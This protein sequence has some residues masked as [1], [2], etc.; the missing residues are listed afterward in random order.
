MVPFE[1]YHDRRGSV[2]GLQESDGGIYSGECYHYRQVCL[3]ELHEVG[4]YEK[5]RPRTA[6]LHY[7][8]ALRRGQGQ[9]GDT[10]GIRSVK[11]I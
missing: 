1:P 9:V 8:Y 3:P 10:G 4:I 2:C 6:A 11:R 5:R 7:G